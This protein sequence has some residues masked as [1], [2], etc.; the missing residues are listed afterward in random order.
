[1][2]APIAKARNELEAAIQGEPSAEGSSPSS[3]RAEFQSRYSDSR[4]SPAPLPEP[5]WRECP[6][7]DR[8]TRVL[9]FLL[10]GRFQFLF[11]EF[12]LLFVEFR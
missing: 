3:S 1:M 5:D 7:P 6:W 12:K 11:F 8:S 2:T 9:P 10:P 4:E